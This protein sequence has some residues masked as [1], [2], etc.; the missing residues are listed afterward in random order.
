M[1]NKGYWTSDNAKRLAGSC[2][3]NT[4]SNEILCILAQ[5]LRYEMW[6]RKEKKIVTLQITM[7]ELRWSR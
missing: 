1:L 7:T 5:L 3:L 6:K 4:G 2:A